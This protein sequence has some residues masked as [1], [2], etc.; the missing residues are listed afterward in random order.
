MS[1]SALNLY[2]KRLN[3]EI[4]GFSDR[5]TTER[6]LQLLQNEDN[7]RVE[8]VLSDTIRRE[9]DYYSAYAPLDNE[10]IEFEWKTEIENAWKK[11]NTNIIS[12]KAFSDILILQYKIGVYNKLNKRKG[13]AQQV[14]VDTLKNLLE[15]KTAEELQSSPIIRELTSKLAKYNQSPRFK[16]PGNRQYVKKLYEFHVY[17]EKNYIAENLIGIVFLSSTEKY[18]GDAFG[19]IQRCLSGGPE[20]IIKYLKDEK[21]LDASVLDPFSTQKIGHTAFGESISRSRGIVGATPGSIAT[22]LRQVLLE[23]QKRISEKG[24]ISNNQIRTII[25]NVRIKK[26]FEF[27]NVHEIEGNSSLIL[28]KTS[29]VFGRKMEFSEKINVKKLLIYTGSSKRINNEVLQPLEAKI[30]A[31]TLKEFKEFFKEDRVVNREASKT[32]RQCLE[33]AMVIALAEG[34][35]YKYKSKSK[36]STSEST[37]KKINT[38][39]KANVEVKIKRPKIVKPKAKSISLSVPTQSSSSNTSLGEILSIL[40][41]SLEMKV[42]ENM[43]TPRLI[44]RTGRFANSVKVN[45]VSM[46]STGLVTITYGYQTYPYQTFEP[47]YEQGSRDRDPR[48]LVSVSIR[49]LVAPIIGNKFRAVRIGGTGSLSRPGAG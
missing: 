39:S 8:A 3:K 37:N 7:E 11:F 6:I 26:S 5:L 34:K 18:A 40:Q 13:Q 38:S 33:E 36:V 45:N 12:E 16:G 31:K 21:L 49:E 20:Q 42:K 23:T 27:Q 35:E 9:L 4:P 46:G 28:E 1:I 14:S 25:Q 30:A 47:G 10:I 24:T 15:A 41:N 43:K 19:A 22:E 29:N 17:S 32:P 2:L 48:S 44:N